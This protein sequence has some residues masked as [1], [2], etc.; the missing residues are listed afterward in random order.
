NEGF[1]AYN[2][3]N[4][5]WLHLA[6]SHQYEELNSIC[7]LKGVDIDA[8]DL[9]GN[10]PLHIACHSGACR[11]VESLIQIGA[12]TDQVNIKNELPVDIALRQGHAEVLKLFIKN[13][14]VTFD[15]ERKETQSALKFV[16]N[17]SKKEARYSNIILVLVGNL[18]A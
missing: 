14:Q 4:G 12:K 15:F 2:D 16:L 13:S 17:E 5:T 11:A 1:K 9:D 8:Q 18:T 6:S 3:R 7:G 10:T